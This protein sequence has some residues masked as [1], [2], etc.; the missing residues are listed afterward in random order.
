MDDSRALI[1]QDAVIDAFQIFFAKNSRSPAGCRWMHS[2]ATR[3][4]PRG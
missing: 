1:R 2:P 3:P 4:K